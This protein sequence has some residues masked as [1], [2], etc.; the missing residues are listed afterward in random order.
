MAKGIEA[1]MISFLEKTRFFLDRELILDATP[2]DPPIY[3]NIR[4]FDKI[5]QS[6]ATIQRKLIRDY[7][8]WYHQAHLLV[9]TYC[10]NKEQSF[11]RFYYGPEGGYGII[12]ILDLNITTPENISK[13]DILQELLRYFDTQRSILVAISE[14]FQLCEPGNEQSEDSLRS[15]PTQ[16]GITNITLIQSQGQVQEQEIKIDNKEIFEKIW[17]QIEESTIEEKIKNKLEIQLGNLE[18][19]QGTPSVVKNYQEF[20]GTIADHITIIQPFIPFLTSL[21]TGIPH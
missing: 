17:R 10:A 3:Q 18:K 5:D 4:R 7:N 12:Q 20:M 15:Q 1:E 9:S 13:D 14:V 2:W 6:S 8:E 19:S 16:A 11:S 21:L